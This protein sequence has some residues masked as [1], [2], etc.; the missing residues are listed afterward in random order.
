MI[1]KIADIKNKAIDSMH[2]SEDHATTLQPLVIPDD[3]MICRNR[4]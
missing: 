3:G 4:Y 1:L 2:I